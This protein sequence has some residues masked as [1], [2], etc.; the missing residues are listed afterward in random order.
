MCSPILASALARRYAKGTAIARGCAAVLLPTDGASIHNIGITSASI[1]SRIIVP[2]ERFELAFTARTQEQ[3]RAGSH[4]KRL[5]GGRRLP[6]A[7][8][9]GCGDRATTAEI[10]P[11]LRAIRSVM[12]RIEEADDFESDDLRYFVLRVPRS[13]TLPLRRGMEQVGP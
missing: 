10:R 13:C 4:C 9:T 8:H 6:N 12:L 3:P 11:E 1:V 7:H 5:L 2:D